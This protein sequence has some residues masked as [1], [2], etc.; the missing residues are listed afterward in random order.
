MDSQELIDLLKDV[1]RLG[2]RFDIGNAYIRRE[3]INQQEAL[4]AR[5]DAA[6]KAL[7][8]FNPSK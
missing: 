2:L 1:Q 5:V 3:F 8:T 4:N 7:A 6:I